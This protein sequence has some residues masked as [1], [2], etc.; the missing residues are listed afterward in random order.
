M[1]TYVTEK[2]PSRRQQELS[3]EVDAITIDR[4][5]PADLV[6]RRHSRRHLSS[7]E[8]GMEGVPTNLR[9]YSGLPGW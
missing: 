4:A 3:L 7:R 6:D 8:S 1:G 9:N 5:W 2:V